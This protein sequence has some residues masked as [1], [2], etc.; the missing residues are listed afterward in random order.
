MRTDS[1]YAPPNE[2]NPI[3]REARFRMQGL[4]YDPNTIKAG[5]REGI[6]E[7]E[8]L[9]DFSEFIFEAEYDGRRFTKTFNA[10]NISAELNRLKP[11]QLST[12]R[13]TKKATT[14]PALDKPL[15]KKRAFVDEGKI[16]L[17]DHAFKH[18]RSQCLPQYDRYC[19][20]TIGPWKHM[21][22]E[23][24]TKQFSENAWVNIQESSSGV[25]E[26]IT[27]LNENKIYKDVYDELIG[28][29]EQHNRVIEKFRDFKEKIKRFP[30]RATANLLELVENEGI[31]MCKIAG[32][33]GEW[34]RNKS[35][36]LVKMRAEEMQ[37]GH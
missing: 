28:I 23:A 32:K 11:E 3:P 16:R 7:D 4:F 9:R 5:D 8:F 13:V 34:L 19:D 20:S 30:E 14:P 15:P 22:L 17:I 31:E 21:L 35:D 36:V 33:Y 6:R 24:S 29:G 18:I 10:A 2:A 26:L 12:P 37:L 27:V 25:N 1:G